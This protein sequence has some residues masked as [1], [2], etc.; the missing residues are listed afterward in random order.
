MKDTGEAH[1]GA[2][3]AV[4]EVSPKPSAVLRP[5]SSAAERLLRVGL[6]LLLASV[7][8]ATKTDPD[9]WGHVR[10]GADMIHGRAIVQPDT[11]SFTSDLPWVNHEWGSEILM[12]A[13]YLAGGD[14]GLCLLKLAV[15]AAI[16]LLL[17]AAL[18]RDG[19]AVGRHRDLVCAL[20]V[21]LTIEQ[22]HNVRPQLFSLLFFSA[23]LACLVAMAERPRALALLPPLFAVWANF[24]GGWIVGGAALLLWTAGLAFAPRP[25][26]R[27]IAACAAAGAAALLATLANPH[28][29]GLHEFLGATVG[30]G[31]ADI[32]EWQPVYMVSRNILALW[33]LAAAIA[34]AGI[35]RSARSPSAAARLIVVVA[36]GA[37]SF[38]VNRLLAFFGLA[39]LFLYGGALATLFAR[40]VSQTRAPRRS[41]AAVAVAVALALIAGAGTLVIKQASCLTIDP[42]STPEAGA[43]QFFRSHASRGR[44][45]VWFDWGEY[46]LWHLSPDLLVSID[47]R[48]ETV[49]SAGLQER[50][51]RFYFDAPGGAA[52]PDEL[53][54][55]YVWIPATIPAAAKLVS[56]GWSEV[57]RS[58][59]S[60][61]F[62]R[63]AL[64]PGPVAQL[65]TTP[66][67]R[68]FPGP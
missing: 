44:L 42:R 19:A 47:G 27:L 20:A 18:R 60:A 43:V 63:A 37:L 30:L 41:G 17:D 9:L 54:A 31:R 14:T 3:S 40:G 16:L 66:G 5:P 36:L 59:R 50:H 1:P 53:R 49:Y 65:G 34:I 7:I 46:A 39:T 10:F 2:P 57:Y 33:L 21:I 23:M 45:L 62:A 58:E 29:I 56:E 61:I 55:D 26:W 64:P 6:F 35:L 67:R 68:C 48:R 25:N 4:P 51:L 11:Y 8:A 38:R 22:A 13:A 24:H 32:V 28:G 15:V 52:L 12:G